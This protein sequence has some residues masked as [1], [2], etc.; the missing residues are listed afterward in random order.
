MDKE[1]EKHAAM[2][3]IDLAALS[4][5]YSDAGV[6]NETIDADAYI[7]TGTLVIQLRNGS[8]NRQITLSHTFIPLPEDVFPDIKLLQYYTE[9]PF[10]GSAKIAKQLLDINHT[11]PC[12]N[13]GLTDDAKVY[14]RYVHAMDKYA[15]LANCEDL[16]S[17]IIN[18]VLHVLNIN[19]DSIEAAG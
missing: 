1:L 15:T 6:E 10:A 11:L 14:F 3:A 7:P 18:L 5:I 4:K 16:L 9:L 13:F 8:K 2:S 19:S 17:S 12:G